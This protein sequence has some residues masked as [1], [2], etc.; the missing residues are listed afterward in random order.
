MKVSDIKDLRE[1]VGLRVRAVRGF[2]GVEVHT[3]GIVDDFYQT[4]DGSGVMVA[5]DL[6]GQP[7]PPSYRK[8]DGRPLVASGILRDGFGRHRTIDETALL[9]VVEHRS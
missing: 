3:E 1:A 2:S 5:W 4:A 8:F 7:L 6:P 9:E